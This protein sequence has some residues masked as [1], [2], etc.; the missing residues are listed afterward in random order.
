MENTLTSHDSLFWSM[1]G[2]RQ[3]LA[4]VLAIISF[5][6]TLHLGGDKETSASFAVIIAIAICFIAIVFI[7][8]CFTSA[9][10]TSSFCIAS[11]AIAFA[12]NCPDLA[13]LCFLL[14][15]AFNG[16]FALCIVTT[17]GQQYGISSWVALF[18]FAVEFTVIFL[19]IWWL[20]H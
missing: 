16:A 10:F 9:S 11:F 19:P 14:V 6:V 13:M 15:F 3:L 1:L 7:D 8:D 20:A 18:S 2:K 5:F 17:E 12:A 4:T